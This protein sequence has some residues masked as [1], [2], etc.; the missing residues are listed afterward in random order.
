MKKVFS[1]TL[2]AFL[3]LAFLSSNSFAQSN[4]DIGQMLKL[5]IQTF[6]KLSDGNGDEIRTNN[7]E[8]LRLKDGSG[9]NCGFVDADGDG[10][11]DNCGFI[12]EDGDGVCDKCGEAGLYDRDRDR[13][14]DGKGLKVRGGKGS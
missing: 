12:D 11:C 5:K 13:L 8:K 7:Q 4:P 9:D 1:L 3:V 14:N 10:I 6:L 2:I